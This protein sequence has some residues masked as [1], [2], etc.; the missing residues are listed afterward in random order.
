[1]ETIVTCPK[2]TSEVLVNPGMG[3]TTFHSF[4][5]DEV[6]KNYPRSSIAYFR[7]Y[8]DRLEPEEGQYRWDIIDDIIAN[9]RRNDQDV[10]LRVSAMNGMN[11]TAPAGAKARNYRVPEWFRNS[12]CRGQEFLDLEWPA[13]SRPIWEPDYGDPLFL[14]KKCRL[15]AELGRRYD[16]HPNLDHV[17]IGSLGRWGEWHCAAVPM[18]PF[19][20]RK[21]IIAAY[22]QAFSKTPLLMLVADQEA[23]AYAVSKGTGWRADCMGDSRQGVFNPLWEGGTADFNHMDDVYLQRLVGAKAT[24]A[25][26]KAPVAF[27]ACWDMK[28][29][30]EQGWS[31]D[32]IFA[33][34][35][36]LHVSIMNNKS[37]PIPEPWWP[38]VNDFSRKLGYRFVLRKLEHPRAVAPGSRLPVSMVWENKGV[39][40]CYRKFALAFRIRDAQG[41]AA[42]V[43]PAK[44]DLNGWLPG[45][46][47]VEEVMALPPECPKGICA[48]SVAIVEPATLNP[49]IKLA[50][51]GRDPDGWHP[52]SRIR[53]E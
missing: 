43:I 4:N 36:A 39:A 22:L 26:K 24:K 6:N 28:H 21:R 17:D 29:W 51:E 46:W 41:G 31:V 32:H 53:I 14:E 33:Y 35:L 10:A 49:M 42:V 30:H 38:Q 13:G 47:A 19:A 7:L 20:A 23:M 44:A 52:L 40:P 45:R 37:S 34:A 15:V 1:M 3:W 2:E 18:P 11:P 16:G 5:G 48:L 50:I 8:W 9:A 25:W 12:G 27:E